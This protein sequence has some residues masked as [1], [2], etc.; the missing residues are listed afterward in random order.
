MLPANT[1]PQDMAAEQM[2]LGELL[3]TAEHDDLLEGIE[4]E[5]FYFS[6]HRYIFTTIRYLHQ[7]SSAI[8]TLTVAD[9]LEQRGLLDKAGNTEYLLQLARNHINEAQAMQAKTRIATLTTQRQVILASNKI[10]D[11]C[12]DSQG[13]TAASILERA[14]TALFNLRHAQHEATKM[15]S[16]GQMT[17]S[18]A[19]KLQAIAEGR[20]PAKGFTTGFNELDE[21][22]YELAPGDLVLV[23]ARPSQG[24]TT[25]AMNLVENAMMQSTAPV[26]VYSLE[27]PSEQIM[28]RLWASMARVNLTH[29]RN[30]KLDDEEWCRVANVMTTLKERGN[31]FIDDAASLTPSD[32]RTR[33]R[34]LI[35]KQGKPSMLMVDYVQ[36]MRVAET[37]KNRADEIAEISNSLKEMAKDFGIPIVALSQLNRSLENRQDKRPI[38]SDLRE[39]GSLEQ[40]ADVILFI[41]RD[42][43]YNPETEHPGEAEIIIGKQRNGP[44]GTAHLLFQGEYSKFVNRT[45]ANT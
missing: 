31:L 15:Q 3:V 1:L 17:L 36:L 37:R 7:N 30:G 14:E 28:M 18:I 42:E 4:P 38:N 20:G 2:L 44:T 35:R 29:I 32:I 43:V 39:S 34:N 16:I 21:L 33:T 40:D 12:Y 13:A 19:D 22:I 6:A 27:M 8:D 11:A 23:A 10:K 9:Y 5:F 24:K 41:Y 25:F 26:V 45:G